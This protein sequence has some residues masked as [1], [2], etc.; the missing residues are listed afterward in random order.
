M[1]E[2]APGPRCSTHARRDLDRAVSR[3][4]AAQTDRARASAAAREAVAARDRLLATTT[5]SDGSAGSEQTLARA[6]LTDADTDVHDAHTRLAH[7]QEAYQEARERAEAAQRAFDVTP[8]GIDALAAE[9]TRSA[10]RH[11][12]SRALARL[13]WARTQAAAITAAWEAS[14]AFTEKRL[15]RARPGRDLTPLRRDLIERRCAEHGVVAPPTD[16]RARA[17]WEHTPDGALH[18]TI[19]AQVGSTADLTFMLPAVHTATDAE[20]AHWAAVPPRLAPLSAAAAMARAR[21]PGMPVWAPDAD[22]LVGA[23]RADGDLRRARPGTFVDGRRGDRWH[24]SP[25]TGPTRMPGA[26]T[27]VDTGWVACRERDALVRA[28]PD[29]D[30]FTGR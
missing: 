19:T 23:V 2:P 12:A 26:G 22:T 4:R 29:L 17:A 14:S 6:V 20:S 1:C 9:V 15:S 16:P 25:V 7:T 18:A 8:A 27:L 10:G 21:A 28:L 13:T 3:A 30:R 11:D 5:T 24:V